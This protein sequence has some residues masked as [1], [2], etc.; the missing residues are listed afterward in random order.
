M[1]LLYFIIMLFVSCSFV[2]NSEI[3]K[4]EMSEFHK[5]IIH[6]GE[7]FHLTFPGPA[8]EGARL[9]CNG[10]N[11]IH[12]NN[13]GGISA[14]VSETYFTHFKPL[15]CT[16]GK[17]VVAKFEVREKNFP[18]EELKV[19]RKKVVLSKKAQVRVAREWKFLNK[20]YKNGIKKPLF[21]ESFA[22]PIKSVI[23][24][25]YGTR[26]TF[27]NIRQ[28]Q[29][30]GTDFRA[31][32]GTPIKA[33]NAGKVVVARDLFYSGKA[34]VIDHGLGIFTVYG[35]LSKIRVKENDMI[36]KGALVG[37]S[38]KTG[39]ITGPHLHW[40]VKVNGNYVDG[41]YLV[42]SEKKVAVGDR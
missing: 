6:P 23:T 20:I 28:S 39:R 5:G 3:Q 13:G 40:G 7:V 26:R 11:F 1:R 14:Y 36:A 38:G 8:I 18:E 34:V 21:Q 31:K 15:K 37:L 29:H 24:S 9:M 25:I 35:H 41:H 27:N 16:Y 42:G 22:L 2:S 33:S 4:S 32:V 12:H 19:I 10:K 30:L 17:R